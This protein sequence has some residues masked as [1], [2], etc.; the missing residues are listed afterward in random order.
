MRREWLG[1]DGEYRAIRALYPVLL[2]FDQRMGA[3]GLGHFLNVEFRRLLG[4]VPQDVF[5]HPLIILTIG[6]LEHLVSAVESLSLEAFLRAYSAADPDRLSSVHNF[7]AHS[8]Y[9]NAVR[10]SSVLSEVM[11]DFMSAARAELRPSEPSAA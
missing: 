10:E 7:I 3:P 9:L 1:Q 6:D 4:T 2:V 11:E 8:D 5:V